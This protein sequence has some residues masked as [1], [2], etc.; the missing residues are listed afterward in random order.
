MILQKTTCLTLACAIVLLLSAPP[1]L[2]QSAT[3][4][5]RP[6]ESLSGIAKLYGV[7]PSALRSYNHIQ[8]PDLINPGLLLQIPAISVQPTRSAT[9]NPPATP[10]GQEGEIPN[11][12]DTG[13]AR[14]NPNPGSPAT[15]QSTIPQPAT[16][17][18]LALV[19]QR[20]AP[21]K[22]R[23]SRSGEI[24]HIVRPNDSL[25]SLSARYRVSIGAIRS[26]NNMRD[27]TLVI[28][29]RLVILTSATSAATPVP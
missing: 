4:T 5:V 27:Y 25:Y 2:A 22:V 29:Q 14:K 8:N 11:R 21:T 6:S 9:P 19:P 15:P 12:S 17:T 26:R 3:H 23:A 16:A 7:S 13:Q 10:I 28:G 20:Q 1:I 18:A 24:N